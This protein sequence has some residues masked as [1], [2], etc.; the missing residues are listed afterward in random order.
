MHAGVVPQVQ[1]VFGWTFHS[2]ATLGI[3]AALVL[4]MPVAG[5]WASDPENCLSCH[6]F[7]GLS[8]LEPDTGELRIFFCSA[9]Y[10]EYSQGPHARLRCTDCHERDEVLVIPHQ[11]RTPVDCTRTCHIST[12]AGLDLRFDHGPVA[13]RLE[14]SVHGPD[15][16]RTVALDPPLLRAGQSTCLY[17]HDQPMFRGPAGPM[18]AP[19]AGDKARCV[20]CHGPEFPVAFTYFTRHVT[21]RMQPSRSVRQLAQVC[22]VCHSDANVLAATGK[23]DAVA[24]YFHSFHGRAN[25]LGS[26]ET[27]ACLD[28]HASAAGDVHAILSK[29]DP[30]SPTHATQLP[31]TCRSTA[32]HPGAAPGLSAAS[33]HLELDPAA[34]TLEF[35]VAALFVTLTAG[36]MIVF[37]IFIILELLNVTVRPKHAE[38]ERLVAVVRRLQQSPEGR[39]RLAR[40]SPHER[41]QHWVLAVNFIV[42][43]VTGM[44]IKLADAPWAGWLVG[45][46]GGLTA[47]R[48][49]HRLCGVLLIAVFLYHL[50]YLAACFVRQV[51]HERRKPGGRGALRLLIESPMML[52]P[53]DFRQ[54]FELFAHLLFL[55]RER[56]RFGRMNFMQKFEYWA[57]FWGMPIMGLSGI[58]LWGTA[59]ITEYVSGRALNFAYIIHSDEAY[60]AFIYIAVVHMFSVILAPV[61]FPVSMGTLTGQIPAEEMAE[62]HRDL[63]EQVAHELSVTAEVPPEKR[64]VVGILKGTVRRGYAAVLCVVFAIIGAWSMRF[65]FAILFTHQTAP[66]EILDIPKR[67]DAAT[68]AAATRA[69]GARDGERPRGPLAHFHQIP[70]WFQ[71]DPRNS[72]ATAGCHAPLPHGRRIEVRAFLNMHATFVDCMVCH[73]EAPATASPEW[74]KLPDRT[75]GPVPAVLRL[76]AVLDGAG[77]VID[78]DAPELNERLKA[79]LREALAAT[80]E[81][82]QFQDWLLRLET[83]NT[84]SRLW[85]SIVLE[86]RDGIR[87]HTHGEYNAKVGLF[88]G[89]ALV[90]RPDAAA[91]SATARYLKAVDTLSQEES[92]RLLDTVHAGVAPAGLMCTPCHAPA[93]THVDFARLGYADRRAREL[94]GSAIVRQVLSVERG[95]AFYLPGFIA[96]SSPRSDALPPGERP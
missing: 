42:L 23:H 68:L 40:M 11:V 69:S 45:L 48:F 49:L 29:E 18:R 26:T 34:R 92:R 10:Y 4:G 15:E 74:F 56:P 31:D 53:R 91:T 20:T 65:L 43:V 51:W 5:T 63:V 78:A 32:C 79:L 6:R 52:T 59:G 64:S 70:P 81:Q 54:F 62:G 94:T 35:Y 24:S 71:A 89:D 41:V 44:P 33:V 83:T 21:S 85:R 36:V 2:R 61:V 75:A 66:V 80:V 27:A 72:C 47:A 14:G 30:A 50:G 9:E 19:A 77:Q 7:R 46:V 25:L 16:L 12:G 88:D 28:C 13:Q 3:L 67:L 38:H 76:A 87:L 73:A 96:P 39:A 37:F 58:A 57:V 93:P 90:G 82:A 22:A 1:S 84:R 95:E 17:C 55:R 60:L 8:R 86:M